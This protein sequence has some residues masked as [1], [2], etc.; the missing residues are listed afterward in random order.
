MHDKNDVRFMLVS[1]HT[2]AF[3]IGV[4]SRNI[5][6]KLVRF[7]AMGIS[8]DGWRMSLDAAVQ[9][10]ENERLKHVKSTEQAWQSVSNSWS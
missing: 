1:G 5:N 6:N 4:T 8:I 3:S 2:A 10:L 9:L 7:D